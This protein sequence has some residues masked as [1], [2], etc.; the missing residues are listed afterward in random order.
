MSVDLEALRHEWVDD[1]GRYW[2]SEC[3][4]RVSRIDNDLCPTR[5]SAALTAANA[6]ADKA[7]RERDAA[8]EMLRRLASASEGFV[9][10]QE[11]GREWGHHNCE[12]A[13][14]LR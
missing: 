4:E 7:E 11:C 2:C 10:C 14:I 8:V 3:F 1:D 5:V 9:P 6:R 12:L 13:A